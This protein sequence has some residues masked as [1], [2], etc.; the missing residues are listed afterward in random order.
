MRLEAPESEK[1]LIAQL[2]LVL[3]YAPILADTEQTISLVMTGRAEIATVPHAVRATPPTVGVA[4][5]TAI[6]PLEIQ[7]TRPLMSLPTAPVRL[8]PFDRCRVA[9]LG[10]ASSWQLRS[11][12]P[13]SAYVPAKGLSIPFATLVAAAQVGPLME[14]TQGPPA[15][16]SSL[17]L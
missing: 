6:V 14:R 15:G 12:Q 5:A 16:S 11:G 4:A 10:A 8:L 3:S 7:T 1:P 2:L 9:A 17:E 13:S